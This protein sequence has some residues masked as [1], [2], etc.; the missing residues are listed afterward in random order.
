MN[1]RISKLG[2]LSLLISVIIGVAL[3]IYLMGQF[4]G[5]SLRFSSLY[6]VSATFPDSKQLSVRSDVD[7]RGVKVGDVQSIHLGRSS[8]TVTFSVAARY[9]PVYR[10]ATVQVGEKTLLGESYINLDPGHRA[11][12]RLPSG[13]R[14]PGRGVLPATVEID[15][16]LNALSP[17]ARRH[18]ISSLETFAA[19]AASPSAPA[20]VGDTLAGLANATAQLRALTSTLQGQE[21]DIA[22]GVEA[23][24]VVLGQLGDR[25]AAVKEIVSGGRATLQ[26]L[27]SRNAALE[28]GITQLPQLLHT[29]QVTLH[30]A[31]P[32][33]VDAGP[34]MSD[35][36]TA[37]PPL[38][39]ALTKLPPVTRDANRVVAGLPAFNA[40]ALPTLS[41]AHTVLGLA[42]P[43][44]LTLPP[45]L[46]NLVTVVQFLSEHRQEVAAWFSNTADLGSG[47]DNKGYFAR[48]FINFD[49]PTGF[50]LPTTLANN[51]YTKPGDAAHNQ[52]YS[53]Y[54]HLLPYTPP[55]P[56][57]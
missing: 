13:A 44:S 47:R 54:P 8:A 37:A 51:P 35:L 24:Q 3:F 10:D 11:A 18:M 32:L 17:S 4:G 53:G 56:K 33:L 46:R 57:R 30:D 14:L 40:I 31:R 2:T 27:A 49:F 34:L 41:L 50:G 42:Q 52:P 20:Q 26:A 22:H 43:V 19:G 5:P 6:T 28:A 36:R 23:A 7:V 48:F 45:A 38:E 29:A 15:Q 25:E 39:S 9:A 12:G 55:P 16:A 1:L 21:G